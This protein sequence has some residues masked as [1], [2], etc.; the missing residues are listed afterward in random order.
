MHQ[1]DG[2]VHSGDLSSAGLSR[3]ETDVRVAQPVLS[4]VPEDPGQERN[5]HGEWKHLLGERYN[6]YGVVN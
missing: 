1:L 4:A 2:G 5:L 6:S 3:R